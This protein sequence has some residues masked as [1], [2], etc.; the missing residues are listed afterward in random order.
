MMN[1]TH[2]GEF[3][4]STPKSIMNLF[5]YKGVIDFYILIGFRMHENGIHFKQ[6]QQKSKQYIKNVYNFVTYFTDISTGF[7]VDMKAKNAFTSISHIWKQ[8]FKVLNNQN[9]SKKLSKVI[10]IE[11][12]NHYKTID[13]SDTF[14]AVTLFNVFEQL[15][16]GNIGTINVDYFEEKKLIYV[17]YWIDYWIHKYWVRLF[18]II[19]RIL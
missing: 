5:K 8:E 11:Y 12:V 7:N 3:D 4:F 10:G 6:F 17:T 18:Y 15:L 2:Y 13:G 19:R 9:E 14:N 1:T 16:H